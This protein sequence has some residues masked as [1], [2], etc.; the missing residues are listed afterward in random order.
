MS[1]PAVSAKAVLRAMM[2]E[3]RST[4]T[5]EEREHAAATVADIWRYGPLGDP[6]TIVAGFWPIRDEFDVR[7]L[8][9][10]LV[11]CGH[12][13]ALPVVPGRRMPLIFRA[14]RPADTL[15][16][17]PF[18]TLQPE[19]TRPEVEPELLLVPL[20]AVDR[21]GYR[22]GYGGGYYDRTLALLRSRS[23]IQAIGVA[24]EM[25][26]LEELPRTATD[27]RLD[28][29]LTEAGAAAFV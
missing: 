13:L 10:H 15:V 16:Q 6:G 14:W 7:P 29:L 18:G 9:M 3:A 1:D 5:Q 26:R 19:P 23:D 22:L 2:I 21:D 28:W 24:F 4:V 20:L 11:S 17:G 12:Q 8:M 27:E 25:Q